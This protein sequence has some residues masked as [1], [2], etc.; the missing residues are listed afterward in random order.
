MND[1]AQILD[2]KAL[3]SEIREEVR[4]YV[5]RAV[6]QGH[7]PPKL[8]AILVGNDGAS[9]TYVAAKAQDCA[10][11]GFDS[12]V[13]R[14]SAHVSEQELLRVVRSLNENPGVDGFIVQLPLPAHID[15]QKILF[16]IDPDKDV[17]GFHP[18]NVGKMCL[19]LSS[20]L[21]ATP[22]GILEMLE[23][24]GVETEGKHV[25]VIGRS[26]IVGRPMSILL[27]RNAR[28]GNATV[29]LCHSRSVHLR[30]HCQ[31]ADILVAA[32]GRPGFVG[33]DLVKPGAVVIDVGIT[34]V[35]DASRKSGFRLSGDVDFEAV[36]PVASWITPVPGGVGPMTRAGLLTNTRR[37]H[38][39][40]FPNTDLE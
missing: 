34:R 26:N 20:F 28:P 6:R 40:R 23:R 37:A 21:P 39:M 7:R 4:G 16:S 13:I 31:S 35:A 1:Q 19:G 8:V 18:V 11:V 22:A 14:L 17:D 3:A 27:S 32:L 29:T 15:E 24:T 36:A 25:V 38:Q 12:E 9:E 10:E 2:G 30:A 33:R 5:E